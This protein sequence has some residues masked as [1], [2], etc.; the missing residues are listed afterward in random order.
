RLM[1][2]STDGPFSLSKVD[3]VGLVGGWYGI[4]L[5]QSQSTGAIVFLSDGMYM[6]AED[7]NSVLDPSGQDG[8]ERGTYTWNPVTG[9]FTSTTVTDTS[10]Q[11][12]LSHSGPN[13]SVTL[14]GST[15]TLANIENVEGSDFADTITGST[16]V[17]V[18][19][20]G[21]G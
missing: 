3:G 9:A 2:T 13:N 1:G 7:G 19:F 14:P 20:G 5:G 4:N 18:L 16:G 11:W 15:D 6:M 10:G 21:G 12:G 8:M 17:N